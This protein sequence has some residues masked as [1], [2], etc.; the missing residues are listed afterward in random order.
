MKL[1]LNAIVLMIAAILTAAA[2][3]RAYITCLHLESTNAALQ[4]APVAKQGLQL[5]VSGDH[6]LYV[7][8]LR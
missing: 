6:T 4:H 8:Q 1:V 5:T 7:E 3:A 2:P